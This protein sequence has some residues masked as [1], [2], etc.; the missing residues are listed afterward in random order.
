MLALPEFELDGMIPPSVFGIYMRV[1]VDVKVDVAGV[2]VSVAEI[3]V[4]IDAP[5]EG[6]DGVREPVAA[7]RVDIAYVNGP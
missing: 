1:T 3:K 5:V 2:K 4:D 6:L 7:V